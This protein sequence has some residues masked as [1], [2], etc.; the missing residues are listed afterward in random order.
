M[1]LLRRAVLPRGFMASAVACG[2]K[3]KRLDLALMYSA[4]PATAVATFTSSRVQAAPLVVSRRHLALSSR[5]HALIVNSGNANCF[6]GRQG[7]RDAQET[8]ALV[9]RS[10]GIKRSEVLVA[11]TGVIGRPMPMDKIGRNIP[12]LVRRLSA[13]GI[14]DASKAILTTDTAS[15]EVTVRWRAGARTVSICGI[16]KGSGMIAPHMATMLAFIFTDAALSKRLISREL[17]GAVD[18]SF[19]CISV[20][21]CMS[22]NDMVVL[23]AN[24][25]AE[26]GARGSD[27]SRFRQALQMVCTELAAMIVRDGEGATKFITIRVEKARTFADARAVGLAIARSPLFKTA[28]FGQ[29]SNYLGRVV[30]AIGASGVPVDPEKVSVRCSDLSKHD[31]TVTVRLGAGGARAGVLTCDLTHDYIKINTE[32]N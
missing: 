7:I 28:M 27:V 23:M 24:G 4:A 14:A 11:S 3:R 19:N 18:T 30:A 16:A 1:E 8:T 12:S 13:G 6:T 31:I 5:M 32:Y 17:K 2:I 21:G 10:L 15:K 25:Q 22:T 26:K 9:A 29:S 20:D